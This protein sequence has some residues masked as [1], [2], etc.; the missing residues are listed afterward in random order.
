MSNAST[1]SESEQDKYLNEYRTKRLE[2]S[3][4]EFITFLSPFKAQQ[5]T[6]SEKRVNETIEKENKSSEYVFISFKIG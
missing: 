6:T 1:K 3:F 5:H 2:S 4:L